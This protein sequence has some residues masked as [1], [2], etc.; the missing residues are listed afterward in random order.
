MSD[1]AHRALGVFEVKALF[2]ETGVHLDDES[3]Q[4]VSQAIHRCAA[5]HA[6]PKVVVVRTAPVALRARLRKALSV[7]T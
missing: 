5:W 6:T 7:V 2:M 4:E 1:L 3:V